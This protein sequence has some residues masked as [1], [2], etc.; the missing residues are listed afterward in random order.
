[1]VTGD[2]PITAKAIAKGVGIISEGSETVEDISARLG[3]PVSEVNPRYVCQVK[4]LKSIS[5][6]IL[7]F[8]LSSQKN[9]DSKK[10][11]LT[12]LLTLCYLYQ[13]MPMP[14]LSMVLTCV[15]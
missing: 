12:M 4:S 10:T 5:W 3:I 8:V 15:T 7:V 14:A 6:L 13:G 2:H 11:S 9:L 1:M